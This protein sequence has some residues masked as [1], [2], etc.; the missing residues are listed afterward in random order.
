M[1]TNLGARRIRPRASQTNGEGRYRTID[2][3]RLH[4]NSLNPRHEPLDD[5]PAIIQQLF[6]HEYVDVLARDIALRGEL[7][8]LDV[9]GVIPMAGNP[10]HYIALEGNRRTC[11]LILL[12]DPNRAPTP[13]IRR[14]VQALAEQGNAPREVHVYEFPDQSAADQWIDLRH[15][16]EQGGIGT[17]GWTPSQ[18][19]AAL[20]RRSPGE[21]RPSRAA[22]Q[23]NLLALAVLDRLTVRGLVSP[24]QRDQV[25]LTTITRYLGTPSVRTLLGLG[26][27]S[28]LI[29]THDADEVDAALARFVL[30][31]LP[32][33]DGIR[34]LVH[35]RAD[36][37][38][39]TAYARQLASAG[40]A[41]TTALAAPSPPPLVEAGGRSTRRRSANNPSLRQRLITSSFVV[42]TSDSALLRLRT[43]MLHLNIEHHEFAANYLLRAFVERIMVLFL[44]ARGRHGPNLSDRRLTQLCTEELT[45]LNA[46]RP[47]VTVV[48]NAGANDATPY[49]LTSLGSAV[50]GGH[51]PTQRDLVSHADTW[52]P[53]LRFMLDSL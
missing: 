53:A 36:S 23:P 4:L 41:P 15:M 6:N 10:G 48:N 49:N 20:A 19:A 32:R 37:D 17:R 18:Q 9:I 30:D 42:E 24:E 16:G 46:P 40:V 34:P 3:T 38:D 11:A 29:Y 7:S 35:S 14:Q 31:S 28:R 5:E 33:Q 27:R 51:F 47:V 26:D 39:R 52:L 22:A 25:S 21:T 43:E 2:V 13:A 45:R 12:A 1:A 44:T 50:H 8:P